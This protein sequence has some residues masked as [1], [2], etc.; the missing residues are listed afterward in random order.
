[1]NNKDTTVSKG[2]RAEDLAAQLLEKKGLK[3]LVRNYLC[4]GGEIDLICCDREQLIFVEVRMRSSARYGGA[5][6][7]INI[8]KQ[9]KIIHAAQHYLLS[10]RLLHKDCR[11]DCVLFDKMDLIHVEWIQNAFSAD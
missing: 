1:M 11:F 6:E 10:H 2:K 7:S 3:V 8:G 4:R 5:G 9:K